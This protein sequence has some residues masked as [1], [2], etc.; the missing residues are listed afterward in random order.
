MAKDTVDT[1][2]VRMEFDNKQFEKNIRQTSKSLD[3]FKRDLDFKGVGDSLEKVKV[4]F[5]SM[6]VAAT[7]FIVNLT[8][9]LI[10]LGSTLVKSFSVDNI[11]AGFKL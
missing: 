10:Q 11:S 4:K 5:S 3:N 8:N 7:T 1:R 2:V 6:Q 9:R